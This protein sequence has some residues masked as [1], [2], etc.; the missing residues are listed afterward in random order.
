[1][2]WYDK[3]ASATYF[4]HFVFPI[5]AIAVLWV[6]AHREWARFMKRF[7]TLLMV[8]CGMFVILPTAPPWMVSSKY[9]ALFRTLPNGTET[10]LARHTG[11]GFNA[12]GL[13]GFTRSWQHALDWGNAIAAMPS[14]HASFALFVPAFFL[15]RVP[16]RWLKALMLC[17][18]VMML[19]SLVYF[20]EHWVIDGIVG[21]ILVGGCFLFWGWQERRQVRVKAN[22][23]RDYFAA[24]AETTDE[25]VLAPTIVAAPA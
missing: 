21:W 9:K 16:W 6:T 2:H 10:K 18:P 11:R 25:F 17:F 15:P 1:V 19:T 20:G 23:A 5:I 8:A 3:V 22:R 12:L 24:P 4:T 14:L 13:H 7:A